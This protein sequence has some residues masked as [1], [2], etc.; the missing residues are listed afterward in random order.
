VIL[1]RDDGFAVITDGGKKGQGILD[2]RIENESVLSFLQRV[3]VKRLVISCSHPHD[4]HMAGL[5][6]LIRSKDILAF[7]RIDFVDSDY[8]KKESLEALYRRQWGH[9]YGPDGKPV[10]GAVEGGGTA[11]AVARHSARNR[12][13]FAEL[14]LPTERL[15]VSNYKYVPEDQ[16]GPHGHCVITEYVL[17][18]AGKTTRLVD[19][20]D[21]EEKLVEKYEGEFR[22][23]EGKPRP[24]V[25]VMPHH[26]SD[27]TNPRPPFL[28]GDK[29]PEAY[30]F[31]V[32]PENRFR[33]PGPRN[34]NACID[35]VGV[36]HVYLTGAGENVVVTAT[37]PRAKT[38]TGRQAD[39]TR[40]LNPLIRQTGDELAATAAA[41]ERRAAQL[42]EALG[43]LQRA[44]GRFLDEPPE[45][46]LPPGGPP[47]D[48]PGGEGGGVQG[49]PRI[50][51]LG[52][53]G[54]AA[55]ERA[56]EQAAERFRSENAARYRALLKLTAREIQAPPRTNPGGRFGTYLALPP[57][58]GGIILGN[59]TSDQSVKP[60]RAAIV[61]EHGVPAIRVEVRHPDGRTEWARFDEMTGAELWAAHR[62]VAPP[63]E[64]VK[65]YALP[66]GE[67]GLIGMTENLGDRWRFGMHPAIAT[68]PLARDAMRLDMV[69]A[70]GKDGPKAL[71]PV[72]RRGW[73]NYQWYDERARIS[74]SGGLVRVEAEAGPKD[75]LMRLRLW[76]DDKEEYL[77]F[78]SGPCAEALAQEF[79][80]LRHIDR[81]AR[82]VAVLHW[83]AR[84]PGGMLPELPGDLVVP[85]YAP[86]RPEFRFSRVLASAPEADAGPL[87]LAW[88]FEKDKPFY[89]ESRTRTEQTIKVMNSDVNQS[90][91]QTFYCSWTPVSV[92]KDGNW[93]L[94]QKIEGVKMSIDIGGN[95]I[96]YDS[97]REG[98]AAN[99]LSDFFK[100]LVGSEF[101]LALDK[102]LKVTRI[103]GRD[104]FVKKLA[105]ASPQMEPLLNQILTDEAL[106]EMGTLAF[107][108]TPGKEV[109]RGETWSRRSDLDLGPVGR[110]E[111]TYEYT[112]EGKDEGQGLILITTDL[113]YRPP[114]EGTAAEPAL[115][116]RI[117]GAELTAKGAGGLVRFDP[118]KG[119]VESA[120][121]TVR[122]GG[123]LTVKVG[124]TTTDVELDQTQRTT[125]KFTDV[126][127]VRGRRP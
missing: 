30:I 13:A 42:R 93:T 2:A 4:D 108:A 37:G 22:G 88:R 70:L 46:F 48:G 91:D 21:A 81:F 72:P 94:R 102:D 29:K 105:T 20:D 124:D 125:V 25:V 17:K 104:A 61:V 3:R 57:V 23:N 98:G 6:E 92:D 118:V 73:G 113:K 78:D 86:V 62:F 117:K 90:Q 79:D 64:M 115:P 114:A 40:I 99:P 83:L 49:P 35:T 5:V 97:T 26:G 31:T 41:R 9:L 103:E 32:N 110:Y 59:D 51:G 12:N 52:G 84:Q 100:Q 109:R 107:G 36:D 16:A 19:F 63:D 82:T 112:Y 89:E 68:T 85:R 27:R 53:G 55:A 122:F 10:P 11:P 18:G 33:H 96:E 39:V 56:A 7:E 60:L 38:Y 95:R 101:T 54:A 111:Q 69:V 47:K 28:D 119:R 65:E 14:G 120:D 67:C 87:R 74:V 43:L 123:K 45:D 75:L 126:P 66:P 1:S 50:P 58:F 80:A 116:Y 34:L 127:P 24:N 121:L 77:S 71:A 76:S 15:E 8:G 106:K 44:R